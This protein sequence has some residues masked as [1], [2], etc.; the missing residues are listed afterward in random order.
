MLTVNG[1][2][3]PA[4]QASIVA[5]APGIFTIPATGLG[6]AI[7]VNLSDYSVAA[8]SGS[9]PGF[10]THPIARGQAYFYVNGLGA[11]TPA[12]ADGSGTC[13]AASGLCNANATPTVFVG[14]ISA[15][16]NFAGQAPA[17]PG[18]NQVNIIVPQNAPTGNSVSLVVQSADGS[19]ISNSSTIA[20]Q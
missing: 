15:Q 10:T 14:G 7:L 2:P 8:P 3:S 17:Y 12:I 16:V 20:V 18:V 4:V 9:L 6:N 5:G 13:T 19:V 1:S 11:M